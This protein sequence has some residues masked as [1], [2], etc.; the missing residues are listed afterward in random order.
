MPY[1]IAAL[2]YAC[3][4]G[5]F[6]L[7]SVPNASNASNKFF[8]PAILSHGAV[9]M[10]DDVL[11]RV[12]SLVFSCTKRGS[13]GSERELNVV[14]PDFWTSLHR[15][16]HSLLQQHTRNHGAQAE[17]GQVLGASADIQ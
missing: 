1:R 12:G 8:F 6:G 13:M 17:Q 14:G 16:L 2:P 10:F 5:T 4:I 3:G 9:D 11:S 7:N 15:Q